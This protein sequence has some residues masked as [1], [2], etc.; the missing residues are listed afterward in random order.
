MFKKFV[1]MIALLVLSGC[2]STKNIKIT[3]EQIKQ[4]NPNH[5]SLTTRNKPDFSAMTAGKA[6]FALI[7]AAA[8]I[9]AGNEIVQENDIDDPA[10]YIQKQLAQELKLAYGFNIDQAQPTL[11]N[12]TNGKKI[13]S[14]FPESDLVLDVQT[15]NWSFGY[16]PTDWD[17]YRV[18]YSAKVRLIETKTQ[19]VIAEGFCYRVPEED[20]TAPSHDELLSNNAA[21]IKQELKIAAD[22]CINEFKSNVL[23]IQTV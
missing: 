6:M 14:Q 8:M 10:H 13:A 4:L 3:Q 20:E 15:I 21:R 18:M 17:N 12:T 23:N 9:A 2:V 7:G 22:Q 1:P 16:F 19:N 11:V 5:V